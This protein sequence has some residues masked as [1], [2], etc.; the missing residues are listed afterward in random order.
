MG[1]ELARLV[2]GGKN[3]NVSRNLH[4]RPLS[5]V[6]R[7]LTESRRLQLLQM[8]GELQGGG[9]TLT[10]AAGQGGGQPGGGGAEE[11]EL[12]QSDGV[13]SAVPSVSW[14]MVIR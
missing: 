4:S 8:D 12:E 10:A 3:R 14:H 13:E 11:R 7:L 2:C 6:R 9:L 5:G 1:L